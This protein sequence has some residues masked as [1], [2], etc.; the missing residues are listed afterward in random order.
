MKK[1]RQSLFSINHFDNILIIQLFCL[2]SIVLSPLSLSFSPLSSPPGEPEKATLQQPGFQVQRISAPGSALLSGCLQV[3]TLTSHSIKEL[4]RITG[5]GVMNK[6]N[7]CSLSKGLT[8]IVR[9]SEAMCLRNSQLN[10]L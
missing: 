2:P 6:P 3:S 5:V 4:N 1:H 8:L 7:H 9:L 10:K